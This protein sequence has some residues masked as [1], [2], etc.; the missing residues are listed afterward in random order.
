MEKLCVAVT[1]FDRADFAPLFPD[2]S[3]LAQ[4]QSEAVL[5]ELA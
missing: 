3:L 4:G 5:A 2:R 1:L